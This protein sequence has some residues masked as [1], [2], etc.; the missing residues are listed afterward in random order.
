MEETGKTKKN[1]K[2][3]GKRKQ[4]YGSEDDK[5]HKR[6]KDWHGKSEL[7]KS[8]VDMS[9]SRAVNGAAEKKSLSKIF[10]SSQRGR[11]RGYMRNVRR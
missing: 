3:N 6:S 11:G 7:E 2:S 10:P 1:S 4:P 5:T 8:G 9:T